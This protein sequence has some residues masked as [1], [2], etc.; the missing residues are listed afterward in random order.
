[1]SAAGQPWGASTGAGYQGG[2]APGAAS[3]SG[4]EEF[5]P[6]KI[7]LTLRVLGRRCDGYHQLESLVAFAN[8]GDWLRVVTAGAL[9]AHADTWSL[10]V[11]GPFASAIQGPNLIAKAFQHLAQD[12]Q[13]KLEGR[14]ILDK[15]LPVASG[16][17]GGSADAAAALRL[18]RAR[19]PQLTSRVDWHALA[20]KLG[21]D[22]PIC[23]ARRSALM[24]GI[25]E[26]VAP[27]PVPRCHVVLACPDL[28]MPANKTQQV[29]AGLNA[30][31]LAEPH[32]NLPVP[33]LGD[34]PTLL[35]YMRAIGNALERPAQAAFPALAAVKSQLAADRRCQHVFLSGAGPTYV[36]VY[37]NAESAARAAAELQTRR[38]RWWVTPSSIGEPAT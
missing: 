10:E 38:P 34:V 7:N 8:V 9:P 12:Y 20:A 37:A 33:H 17:G 5:A 11:V 36:G 2:D 16:I 21:A 32:R 3:G 22:V 30:P 26:R 14:Y 27:V 15:R 25:G 24:R 13:L 35:Q 28:A 1:M 23:F 29:F 6:A 18:V 19:H 4:W 31:A